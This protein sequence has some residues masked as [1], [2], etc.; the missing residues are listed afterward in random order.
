MALV[1]PRPV[2]PVSESDLP[3]LRHQTSKSLWEG[4]AVLVKRRKQ[5]KSG[6]PAAEKTKRPER[7]RVNDP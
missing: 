7:E 2:E 4:F 5:R 6:V 3:S 1:N